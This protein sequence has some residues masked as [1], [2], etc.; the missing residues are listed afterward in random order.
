MAIE[1]N[2]SF[3]N[4]VWDDGV[5]GFTLSEVATDIE[6]EHVFNELRSGM[7]RDFLHDEES[8]TEIKESTG[9]AIPMDGKAI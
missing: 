7:F 3:K 9:F 1:E 8:K 2:K 4:N 5:Y 6:G